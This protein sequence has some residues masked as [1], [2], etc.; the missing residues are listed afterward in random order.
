M[1][2]SGKSSAV[3]TPDQWTRSFLWKMRRATSKPQV[4][5][6]ASY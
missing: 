3:L 1:L 6:V 5:S 2:T 4:V